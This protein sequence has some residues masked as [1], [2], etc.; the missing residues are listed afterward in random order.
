MEAFAKRDPKLVHPVVRV[1][2]GRLASIL[3]TRVGVVRGWQRERNECCNSNPCGYGFVANPAC[4]A[5]KVSEKLSAEGQDHRKLVCCCM[6]WSLV[7][8]V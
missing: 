6:V 4:K 8:R 5:A 1:E 3:I 7:H 2:F